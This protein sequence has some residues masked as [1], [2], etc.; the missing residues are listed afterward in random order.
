MKCKQLGAGGAWCPATL[1]WSVECFYVQRAVLEE[2]LPSELCEPAVFFV[3]AGGRQT[4]GYSG[5]VWR[6]VQAAESWRCVVS[7]LQWSVE[8]PR[9]QRAV[10][11]EQ[12]LS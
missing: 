12:L 9:W 11:E 7:R 4:A 3:R 1:Q 6:A 5:G 10:L 8:C 2:Q